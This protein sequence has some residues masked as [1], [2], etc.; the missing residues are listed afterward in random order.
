MCLCVC[1][2]LFVCVRACVCVCEKLTT[3]VTSYFPHVFY[4]PVTCFGLY[5]FIVLCYLLFSYLYQYFSLHLYRPPSGSDP[6]ELSCLAVGHNFYY[7]FGRVLDGTPCQTEPRSV[8]VN[9]KCLVSVC[10]VCVCT[11]SVSMSI[12]AFCLLKAETVLNQAQFLGLCVCVA[13]FHLL[14]L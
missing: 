10:G 6:C 8:C 2:C 7:N 13:Y 5:P 4:I 14:S 3:L 11:F 9:G 12:P 1:V